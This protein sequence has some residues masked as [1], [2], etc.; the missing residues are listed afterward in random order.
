MTLRFGTVAGLQM[1][2]MRQCPEDFVGNGKNLPLAMFTICLTTQGQ[3][4]DVNF[5][6]YRCEVL[7]GSAK[8]DEPHRI[9][10]PGY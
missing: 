6:I 5:T 8:P 3:P 7:S 10:L 4:A 1:A 9:V 2:G